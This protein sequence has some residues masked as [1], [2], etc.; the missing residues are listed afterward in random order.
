MK[1]FN[2]EGQQ[3]IATREISP[4]TQRVI[5]LY[6][7]IKLQAGMEE[8][9]AEIDLVDKEKN[10]EVLSKH[11]R[12]TST[13]WYPV[14]HYALKNNLL[15]PKD[16]YKI[17][18]P[19]FDLNNKPAGPA[20]LRY[21][22]SLLLKERLLTME[23]IMAFVDGL[24]E[25]SDIEVLWTMNSNSPIAPTNKKVPGI[26]L[27][28]DAESETPDQG[29]TVNPN[30]AAHTMAYGNSQ[31]WKEDVVDYLTHVVKNK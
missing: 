25:G 22:L 28:D 23:H 29:E 19:A 8:L 18:V 24:V 17:F 20:G 5:D 30:E 1:E 21:L 15:D 26:T 16:L 12:M 10:V 2:P 13:S 27:E 7:D 6:K 3:N 9:A 14:S 31:S 11:L 4:D